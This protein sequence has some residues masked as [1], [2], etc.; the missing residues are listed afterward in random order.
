[1]KTVVKIT[2]VITLL[3]AFY[4]CDTEVDDG[5]VLILP[6]SLD[7]NA[8][9]DWGAGDVHP[10]SLIVFACE[11]YGLGGGCFCLMYCDEYGSVIAQIPAAN[12][13]D[14]FDVS[15]PSWAPNRREVVCKLDNSYTKEAGL[16]ICDVFGNLEL[17]VAGG[18]CG[19]PKW[20]PDG[21][22]I[23]YLLYEDSEYNIFVID[24]GGGTPR[25]LTTGGVGSFDWFPD[26]KRLLCRYQG[27]TSIDVNTGEIVDLSDLT[28][29]I[30]YMDEINVSPDGEYVAYSCNPAGDTPR[31][32]YILNLK[33]K[34]ICR[35]TAEKIPP[36]EE[37]PIPMMH[38]AFSPTWSSDGK[39]IAFLSTRRNYNS[40][41]LYKIRVF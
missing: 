38:G 10:G 39:S 35:V 9:P 8:S 34:E 24:V 13:Y 14:P 15:E 7:L 40:Y 2:V 11:N 3:L 4:A 33:T 31:D 17:L 18:S 1:M 12:D 41:N 22:K 28:S 32:I 37:Y 5:A 21:S 20:S 23:A 25:R 30:T 27:L 29:E 19:K 26:G 16:Y 36:P 6:L